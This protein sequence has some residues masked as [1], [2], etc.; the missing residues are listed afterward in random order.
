MC[1]RSENC[2]KICVFSRLF[3]TLHGNNG[4]VD[5]KTVLYHNVTPGCRHVPAGL[6]G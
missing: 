1:S 5:E 4:I 2:K 6:Q 3:V